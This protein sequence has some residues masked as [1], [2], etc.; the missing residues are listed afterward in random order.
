MKYANILMHQEKL[1]IIFEYLRQLPEKVTNLHKLHEDYLA[2]CRAKV[3]IKYAIGK[4][5]FAGIIQKLGCRRCRSTAASRW[6]LPDEFDVEE[7]IELISEE[8]N[9]LIAIG[10]DARANFDRLK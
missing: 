8:T 1:L 4:F 7:L 6:I 5:S 3:S 9:R 2:F 10:D